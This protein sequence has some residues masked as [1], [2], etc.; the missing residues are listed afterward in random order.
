MSNR[1]AH[2]KSDTPPLPRN[3]RCLEPQ[4]ILSFRL[5]T[6][7][8]PKRKGRCDEPA[9]I[10]S[11]QPRLQ[12]NTRRD[13]LSLG[14]PSPITGKAP[15]C[16]RMASHHRGMLAALGRLGVARIEFPA[17]RAGMDRPGADHLGCVGTRGMH[18]VCGWP[19]G[20]RPNSRGALLHKPKPAICLFHL[21]GIGYWLADG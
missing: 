7:P 21:G 2:K 18:A 3:F 16:P 10:L 6:C 9:E 11:S 4:P 14:T 5:Y 17:P 15:S 19:K 8:L 13:Q 1:P 12:C 20:H